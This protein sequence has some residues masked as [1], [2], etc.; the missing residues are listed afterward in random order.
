MVVDPAVT[1]PWE[2][3]EVAGRHERTA[4][5]LFGTAIDAMD[6]LQKVPGVPW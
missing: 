5:G 1:S 4:T 6:A 2:V 3:P